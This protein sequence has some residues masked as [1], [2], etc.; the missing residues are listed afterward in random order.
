MSGVRPIRSRFADER[1]RILWSDPLS[2]ASSSLL[3]PAWSGKLSEII[4]QILQQRTHSRRNNGAEV[5]VFP[6]F[7]PVS[8]GR[9]SSPAISSDGFVMVTS[10]K[11][12]EGTA[13]D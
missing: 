4:H 1:A 12:N 8:R 3:F 6:V 9:G 13:Y 2:S 10:S 11:S 7:F 5:C